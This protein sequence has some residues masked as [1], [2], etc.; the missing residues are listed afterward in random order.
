M[1][2]NIYQAKKGNYLLILGHNEK[3]TLTTILRPVENILGSFWYV[4]DNEDK[5]WEL[6]PHLIK[7][8]KDVLARKRP[9]GKVSD[10]IVGSILS[11]S[12]IYKQCLALAIELWKNGEITFGRGV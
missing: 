2:G 6:N 1:R 5:Q 9:I 3:Y 12:P 10:K 11:T 4:F 8:K 7:T